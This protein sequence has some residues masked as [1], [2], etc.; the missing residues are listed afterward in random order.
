MEFSMSHLAFICKITHAYIKCKLIALEQLSI[1]VLKQTLGFITF[2]CVSM[3]FVLCIIIGPNK[4]RVPNQKKNSDLKPWSSSHPE[5]EKF[6]N[7]EV[8][9]PF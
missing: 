4:L 8:F 1:Y 5:V 3:G 2:V 7:F 6:W 9:C